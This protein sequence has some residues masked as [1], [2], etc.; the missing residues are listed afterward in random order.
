MEDIVIF[1]II[2][3]ISVQC[4]L[5]RRSRYFIWMQ[6]GQFNPPLY[7]GSFWAQARCSGQISVEIGKGVHI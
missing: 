3:L 4:T 2:E 6:Y 1:T 7:T 5:I